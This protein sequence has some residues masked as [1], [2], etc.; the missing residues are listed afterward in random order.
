M[1]LIITCDH[2]D[3]AMAKEAIKIMN[4]EFIGVTGYAVS[5]DK[6][7]QQLTDSILI[8]SSGESITEEIQRYS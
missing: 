5:S 2:C 8:N 4:T 7:L 1:M 3:E 6:N